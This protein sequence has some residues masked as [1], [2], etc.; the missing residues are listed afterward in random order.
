M[1]VIR[2]SANSQIHGSTEIHFA[3]V[4]CKMPSTKCLLYNV[5]YKMPAAAAWGRFL[6]TNLD[7]GE[8]NI[9]S[10]QRK[11]SSLTLKAFSL[12]LP[13]ILNGHAFPNCLS[14]VRFAAIIS[15]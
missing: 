4:H 15:I 2:R 10:R 13:P 14:E 6:Q 5:I 9:S 1:A 12:W 3:N 11:L 8:S 7:W